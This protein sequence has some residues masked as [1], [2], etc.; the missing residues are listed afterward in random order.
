MEGIDE[1]VE[2]EEEV[3]GVLAGEEVFVG[4]EAVGEAIAAGSGLTGR[5]TGSGRFFRVFAIGVELG[6]GGLAGGTRFFSWFCG[7]R[8]AAPYLRLHSTPWGV[9][10]SG[11]DGCKWLKTGGGVFWAGV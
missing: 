6:G 4:A 1:V 7:A 10:G 11:V 9:G 8:C 5:G 2:E 3:F